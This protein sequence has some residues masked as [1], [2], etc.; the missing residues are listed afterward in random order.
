[1]KS[2]KD[3]VVTTEELGEEFKAI[4]RICYEYGMAYSEALM[5]TL[6]DLIRRGLLP[7]YP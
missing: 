6:Y 2:D 7:L 5:E 4:E 3:I 1:M